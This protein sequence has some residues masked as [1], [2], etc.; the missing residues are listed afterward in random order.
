M[1][2]NHGSFIAVDASD[3]SGDPGLIYDLHAFLRLRVI[4]GKVLFCAS[5]CTC[6]CGSVVHDTCVRVS[7]QAAS[8]AFVV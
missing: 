4:R 2:A 3:I 7:Q 6:V 1:L 5:M 8:T